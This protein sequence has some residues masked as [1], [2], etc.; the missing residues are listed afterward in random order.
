MSDQ[1]EYDACIF[2]LAKLMLKTFGAKAF[3]VLHHRMEEAQD[4]KDALA[5]VLRAIDVL[6][7]EPVVMN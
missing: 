1:A 7:D 3:F 4:G 5:D 2:E 6:A